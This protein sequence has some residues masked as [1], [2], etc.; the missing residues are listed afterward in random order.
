[1]RDQRLGIRQF[2]LRISGFRLPA[3]GI[4]L[5]FLSRF[6]LSL[7]RRQRAC[8]VRGKIVRLQRHEAMESD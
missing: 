2:R 7:Q 1:M 4:R 5:G 8:K 3:D 6:T